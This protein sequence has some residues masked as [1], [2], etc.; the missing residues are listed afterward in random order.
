[1]FAVT[2]PHERVREAVWWRQGALTVLDS[3]AP[4]ALS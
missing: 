2:V 4:P 3:T 1:M